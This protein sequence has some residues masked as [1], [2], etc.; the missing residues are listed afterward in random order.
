MQIK[1]IKSYLIDITIDDI[2]LIYSGYVNIILFL[3]QLEKS[4]KINSVNINVKTIKINDILIDDYIYDNKDIII[5]YPFLKSVEYNIKIDFDNKI[6]KELVGLYY[7][8]Y[9]NGKI[10]STQFESKYCRNFIPCFDDPKLKS[11]FKLI[12]SGN[13]ELT[14][15]SNMPY[16]KEE[17]KSG[18]KKTYFKTTP[19]M[20]TYLLCIVIGK[21]NK[22]TLKTKSGIQVNS[23]NYLNNDDLKV[24]LEKTVSSIEYFEDYFKIKYPLPKLDIVPIP[25]FSSSAMENWGLITFRETSLFINSNTTDYQKLMIIETIHHEIA[26]QWFGNLVTMKSWN[27]LW[28]NESMATFFSFRAMIDLEKEYYPENFIIERYKSALMLDGLASTHPIMNNLNVDENVDEVFDD[29]TY[30]KGASILFFLSKYISKFREIIIEYL[31]KYAYQNATTNDFIMMFKFKEDNNIDEIFRE[32]ILTKNYPI[33]KIK[34]TTNKIILD[35]SKFIINKDVLDKIKINYEIEYFISDV[36]KKI[37]L[38]TQTE[39]PINIDDRFYISPSDNGLLILDYNF[40]YDNKDEI[41]YL[42]IKL[43]NL[44][45]LIYICE[46]EYILFLSNIKSIYV[47]IKLYEYTLYNVFCSFQI[48]YNLIKIICKNLS[49]ILALEKLNKSD[50]LIKDCYRIE[51]FMYNVLIKCLESKMLFQ[52][53]II[54]L[55]LKTLVIIFDNKNAI[56]LS[57]KLFNKYYEK[58]KTDGIFYLSEYLFSIMIHIDSLNV[59]SHYYDIIKT[60]RDNTANIFI[61]QNAEFSLITSHQQDKLIEI[62]N[63]LFDNIKLQDVPRYIRILLKNKS[64]RDYM[65]DFLNKNI[66]KIKQFSEKQSVKIF[67]QIKENMYDDEFN[68]KLIELINKNFSEEIL[69]SSDN[70]FRQILERLLLNTSLNKRIK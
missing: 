25:N 35:I 65:L 10:I 63:N 69:K 12:I 30:S 14:Y 64:I 45:D 20:S 56:D 2:K 32:L 11:Q 3:D 28:L 43:F 52:E 4:I 29:I 51:S 36:K 42:P 1:Q 41:P 6:T 13:P 39:I 7:S 23:Y 57:I 27:D 8:S 70:V 38:N 47:I 15:L 19:I 55:L 33:L 59:N 53:E 18:I 9:P 17:I 44:K 22:K 66:D 34:R 62:I 68:N 16:E 61:K 46:T 54:G 48:N 21:L 5:N 50:K 37:N 26:H 40:V 24:S 49:D 31:N 60:I 58:Y 67:R